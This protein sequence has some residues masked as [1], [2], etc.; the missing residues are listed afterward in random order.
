MFIHDNQL[1]LFEPELSY[2]AVGDH[3]PTVLITDVV[4][5]IVRGLG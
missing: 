5:D 2:H 3:T 4:R 1:L